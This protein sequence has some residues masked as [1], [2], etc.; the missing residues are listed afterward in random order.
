MIH[1]TLTRCVVLT[2][3]D[4]PDSLQFL[5]DAL[6]AAGMTVLVSTG[7]AHAL[8]LLEEIT[9][10]IVLMDA[11][12]PGLNG[13]ETCRRLKQDHRFRDLPVIFMTGLSETEHVVSGFQAGG[14]DYI[15]K[16]IVAD[17]LI[18]RIQ[19]HRKNAQ[20][21]RSAR[22][23]LDAAGRALLA[24]DRNAR[25]KWATAQAAGLLRGG[26]FAA[27]P[28]EAP[29]PAPVESW[30][31]ASIYAAPPAK[32]GSIDLTPTLSLAYVAAIGPDEFLFSI[33]ETQVKNEK[34]LFKQ[35]YSLTAR[36]SDVL[37]WIAKGK[38]NR[39]IGEILGLSPRTVNK[40]LEQIY[41]KLGVENRTAAAA[42]AMELLSN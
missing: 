29:L 23:A 12:M 42:I 15:T 13:F 39:D 36:E 40:H 41:A 8:A 1:D 10:D 18:A 38:S 6:N 2:I 11:V 31:K 14:V 30:I 28:F 21:T 7:G 16:P 3:D 24:V 17:E 35:H 26:D 4:S 20:L 27:E 5:T 32:P 9:P 25:L 19:V 22:L 34:Q 33:S 37:I